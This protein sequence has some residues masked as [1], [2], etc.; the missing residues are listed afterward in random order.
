[1]ALWYS[2]EID[3]ELGERSNSRHGDLC[4][5]TN[6]EGRSMPRDILR[7]KEGVIPT[8]IACKPCHGVSIR[9]TNC[10]TGVRQPKVH[11]LKYKK[12]KET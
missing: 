4:I 6:S 2:L 7:V 10:C 11:M 9:I 1:M 3:R 8:E 5:C 12:V